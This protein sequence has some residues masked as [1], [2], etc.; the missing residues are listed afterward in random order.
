MTDAD[1]VLATPPKVA[2]LPPRGMAVPPLPLPM[3]ESA[4]AVGV[5]RP[6]QATSLARSS[7]E[8]LLGLLFKLGVGLQK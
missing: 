2:P 7:A 4:V 1:I 5:C 8:G 6:L 3:L